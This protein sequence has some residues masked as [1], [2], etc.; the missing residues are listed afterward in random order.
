MDLA[1]VDGSAVTDIV[2]GTSGGH[3]PRTAFERVAV[4]IVG[5]P[6]DRI[7]DVKLRPK[8]CI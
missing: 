8:V 2:G 1:I 6:S 4:D 3:I 5:T 7:S